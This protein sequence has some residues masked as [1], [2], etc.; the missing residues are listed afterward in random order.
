MQ[1]GQ[2]QHLISIFMRPTVRCYRVLAVPGS[3]KIIM[4]SCTIRS[5]RS[6][7]NIQ[8]HNVL[9]LLC[10]G[11]E[12]HEFHCHH[13][14]ECIPKSKQCDGVYNCMDKSDE[15]NCENSKSVY[16]N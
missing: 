2:S 14:S 6:A 10:L 13:L 16:A 9:M 11:C 12:P 15:R 8:D 7:R 1:D 5:P 4:Y 3:Y